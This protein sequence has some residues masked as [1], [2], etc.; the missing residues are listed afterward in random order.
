MSL[1]SILFQC[2]LG[3]IL[4]S[5]VIRW[6]KFRRALVQINNYPGER[7]VFGFASLLGNILPYIPYISP[8]SGHSWRTK[9]Q[10]FDRLGTDIYGGASVF[11]PMSYF[12]ASDPA[13]VKHVS[14]SRN[15][16]VK[17]T[18]SYKILMGFGSNLLVVEGAEWKRQRRIAAPAFSD[19]NNRLVWDTAKEFVQQMIN[20]WK[21]NERTITADVGEE[22][23]L[24]LSLCVIAKAGFGQDVSWGSDPIPTGHK[25]SF[26]DALSTASKTM[27]F[28]LM[29]PNWAWGLRR[30][31]SDAKQA[32]DELRSYLKEMISTR[33]TL[34]EQQIREIINSRYDLF[35]QLI[36]ARDEDDMLTE[37]E[38]VG[39]VFIFMIAGHET[40]AHT[41][42]IILSML[43]L[44][45]EVQAKL[46]QQV[47]Q[48]EREHGNLTYSHIQ[49][50]TY[51]M[52][53]VYE[54]LRLFPMVAFMPKKSAADTKLTVGFPPNTQTIQVPAS[55]QIFVYSTGL[56]YH[57]GYWENPEEFDPERFMDPHWNR[58]AFIAFSLGP[59]AC[60]GR[61]F[62]ETSLVAELVTLISKYS[63]A[64]D[65]TRFKHIEGE[66]IVERRSRL[67]R[68]EIRLTLSPA[69]IPLM[70]SPRV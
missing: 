26:K 60:I 34:K 52:A 14:Y 54:T 38:L 46:A 65:N 62:A 44:Y 37:D 59:R 2:M 16:F 17:N 48:L 5:T 25:L 42:A 18:E 24:P 13:A 41:L 20:T 11:P 12:V 39:N 36:S 1:S 68:P 15:G 7:V 21:P 64:V 27:H 29:I 6:T 58:D 70:F 66:S 53:V 35:S 50:L 57:P 31:W 61:R 19:K 30:K 45:P 32:H 47:Q 67:I 55:T 9:Y 43:A 33:R 10:V 56:H 8:G 63:V 3:Y 28:P 40:T 4:V 69:A 23:S 22:V 49:L 51:A